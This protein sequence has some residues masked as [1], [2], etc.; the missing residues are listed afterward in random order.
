MYFIYSP[1]SSTRIDPPDNHQCLRDIARAALKNC[2]AFDVTPT[3]WGNLLRGCNLEIIPREESLAN[4]MAFLA[5][6]GYAEGGSAMKKIRAI[7]DRRRGAI[8]LSPTRSRKGMVFPLAHELGHAILPWHRIASVHLDD[9]QTLAPNIRKRFEREASFVAGE[10]LFQC[11]RFAEKLR[12]PS[13]VIPSILDLADSFEATYKSALFRFVETSDDAVA[14]VEYKRAGLHEY[15]LAGLVPPLDFERRFT[16]ASDSFFERIGPIETPYRLPKDSNWLK[17]TGI[18]TNGRLDR[19][20]GH[21][22]VTLRG[23]H[24][25]HCFRWESFSNYYSLFVLLKPAK[26]HVEATC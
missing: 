16:V 10:L 11:G 8:W 5:E 6:V 4:L 21:G 25:Q 17:G 3:P 26:G 12:R 20:V 18:D 23:R 14:L 2:N 7:L 1:N 9:D 24:A 22:H 19:A 13:L 15:K